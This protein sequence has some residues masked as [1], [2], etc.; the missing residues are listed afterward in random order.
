[1]P[2]TVQDRNSALLVADLGMTI[3]HSKERKIVLTRMLPKG[4]R[5]FQRVSTWPLR[6]RGD[7]KPTAVTDTAD[8]TT[9]GGRS[10][11]DASG[12]LQR[13]W[14]EG[15]HVGTVAEIERV[16]GIK[17][18]VQD[19]IKEDSLDLAVGIETL[20]GMEQECVKSAV[21]TDADKTRSMPTW[22]QTAAHSVYDVNEA[23]RPVT[24]SHYS[25]TLAEYHPEDLEAQLVAMADQRGAS[26]DLVMLA[27]LLLHGRVSKWPQHVS[28]TDG[29]RAQTFSFQSNIERK[30]EMLVTELTF[31]SGKVRVVGTNYLYRDPANGEATAKT[32]RSGLLVNPSDWSL[33]WAKEP[34]MW[35]NPNLGGGRRGFSD[36][37][38]MLECKMPCGQ[39]KIEISA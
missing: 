13:T 28:E 23:F 15:W 35:E 12:V 8:K 36:A 39:G 30:I 3:F 5:V 22:L 2:I 17:D 27:G 38:L 32:S 7:V 37:I 14:S 21:S 11:Y 24:A 20:L 29:S 25:G 31:P 16:A 18:N 4:P 1:M 26:M 6:K 9:Y 19:E 34:R 33:R 10:L